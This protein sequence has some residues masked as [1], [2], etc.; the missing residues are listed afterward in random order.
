MVSLYVAR[1]H[2]ADKEKEVIAAL[3]HVT[4]G[5][6]D[7]LIYC[8][9][10]TQKLD[11]I[12]ERNI[13]TLIK[14]FG[15]KIWD[16]AIFVLTHADSVLE[17]ENS[18]LDTLITEFSEELQEILADK[19]VDAIVKPFSS[20]D[21]LEPRIPTDLDL[22]PGETGVAPGLSPGTEITPE[23]NIAAEH[24]ES[25]SARDHRVQQ[26]LQIERAQP[27]SCPCSKT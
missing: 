19:E 7:I 15:G 1:K 5:N 13:S 12:D 6:A 3:S 21:T 8:V 17:D 25:E 4:D 20:C 24:E 27:K 22:S 11:V 14:A 10:L 26:I 23:S 18:D 9:N 16:G 2:T